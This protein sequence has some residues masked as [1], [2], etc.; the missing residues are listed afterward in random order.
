MRRFN[1]S[2]GG[3]ACA[4]VF[5]RRFED[6]DG[7]AKGRP[8]EVTL[9]AKPGEEDAKTLIAEVEG[10]LYERMLDSGARAVNRKVVEEDSAGNTATGRRMLADAGV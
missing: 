2:L 10:A 6:S 3:L 8:T 4:E 1:D 7:I 5:E 9:A